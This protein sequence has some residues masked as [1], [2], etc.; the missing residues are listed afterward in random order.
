M[1]CVRSCSQVA[2]GMYLL[3]IGTLCL[4]IVASLVYVCM[5]GGGHMV[6]NWTAAVPDIAN[7]EGTA[8]LYS[9]SV[10][11]AIFFGT[12]HTQRHTGQN[13]SHD[14]IVILGANI[15]FASLSMRACSCVPVHVCVLQALRR[16]CW[17]SRALRRLL[18]SWRSS[19][20][21]CT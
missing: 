2:L 9:G 4:L 20:L 5:N 8:T 6:E 16:V 3:H 1:I 19:V 15:S 18:T 14:M 11:A 13:R 7:L 10:A 12:V 17:V 21:V